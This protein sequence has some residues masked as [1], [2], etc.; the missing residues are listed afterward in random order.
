MFT[1][2]RATDTWRKIKSSLTDRC[3]IS[4]LFSDHLDSPAKILTIQLQILT[5]TICCQA[6]V[7]SRTTDPFPWPNPQSWVCAF[8]NLQFGQWK[9]NL[10]CLSWRVDLLWQK[11]FQ[12]GKSGGVIFG[13]KG[14]LGIFHNPHGVLPRILGKENFEKAP[15]S[16]QWGLALKWM[17]EH[18]EM[19]AVINIAAQR[20]F[21][22]VSGCFTAHNDHQIDF[23]ISNLWPLCVILFANSS[24]LPKATRGYEVESLLWR[25]SV[26]KRKREIRCWQ[27]KEHLWP[28]EHF[29]ETHSNLSW[30]TFMYWGSFSVHNAISKSKQCSKEPRHSLRG[31]FRWKGSYE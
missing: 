18:V 11:Y 26:L 3:L 17:N 2:R 14:K 29:F 4:H 30:L 13:S 31:L 8:G 16:L 15:K 12:A 22:P 27:T 28:E 25:N 5:S 24:L 20:L 1:C 6:V 9:K 23:L 10:S 21:L 19:D 7:I